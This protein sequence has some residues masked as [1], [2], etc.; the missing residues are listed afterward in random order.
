MSI[1]MISWAFQQQVGNPLR[2]LILIKLADNANDDGYAWPSIARIANQ[3][4]A[5]RDSVI[6]HIAAL[7][8]QGLLETI[9]RKKD[10]VNLPNH[11]RLCLGGS[12][13][14]RPLVAPSDQ[15]VVAQ[16]DQGSSRVRPEPSFNRHERQRQPVVVVSQEKEK[17]NDSSP[18]TEEMMDIQA[19]IAG[20]A[21]EGMISAGAIRAAL[22][23]YR[24]EV[25]AK[26]QPETPQQGIKRILRWMSAMITK[27]R[28]AFRKSA[29]GF[30]ARMAAKGMDKP[31]EVVRQEQTGLKRRR[32]KIRPPTDDEMPAPEEVRAF[33][34]QFAQQLPNGPP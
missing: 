8:Q 18:N 6:R 9:R 30:L 27:D 1:N 32:E 21:L 34:R 12:S 31:E 19:C 15:G 3:T 7:E 10:G 20:T 16:C 26:H 14:V 28:T 13:T 33:V 2:K 5:S 23:A 17:A 29:S 25:H 4:E 22:R 24:P 11:Y